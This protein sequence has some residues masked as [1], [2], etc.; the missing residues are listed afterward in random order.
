MLTP[1]TRQREFPSLS[2]MTYLNT[3]AE[4]IPPLSVGAALAQYY[5]D[6]QLGMDGRDRHF[7]ELRLLQELIGRFYGLSADETAVCSCTSEAY[8]LLA[9]AVQ[10][11]SGD[12]VIVNDLDFP[13]GVTPWLQAGCPATTRI[14]RSV[15]GVLRIADLAELLSPR[16]RLVT[17]SYVS[18]FNGF[19]VTLPEVIETVR[20][21]SP[22]LMAVDVTQALGRVPLDLRGADWIV[23]ST[24]KWILGPHGGGLIG[25]PRQRSSDLTA[26]AGGWYNLEEPFGSERFAAVTSQPG[27]ASYAV[28][29]PNFPAVYATRAALSYIER[30]GV[31]SIDRAA[32]PV[33]DECFERL[34]KLPITM[35]TNAGGKRAGILAFRHPRAADIHQQ[36]RARNIHVMASAGRL[37]VAIH[38][39]N[40]SEDV[41]HLVHAL[42]SIL[43]AL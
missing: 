10:L 11:Q 4:G 36:L 17:T 25:I 1:V 12:E 19:L 14:W 13:A 23:S 37:R 42:S 8:N 9:L 26:L 38:G 43:A 7:A 5:A 39:Y 2:T 30:I 28:G 21:H 32:R 16:T 40:T 24:H 20:R 22:A 18:F 15:D 27:A 41:D 35:L 34:S 29:M 6:K 31:D 33:V 3:A